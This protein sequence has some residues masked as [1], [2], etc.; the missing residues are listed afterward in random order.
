MPDEQ[1]IPRVTAEGLLIVTRAKRIQTR[2]AELEAV[3]RCEAR[4]FAITSPGN[5][6]RW[7]LLEVAVSRWR[8]MEAAAAQ[9]GPFVYSVTRTSL[10]A[11]DLSG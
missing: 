4:M 1:W 5:L 6:G 10:K 8:D 2:T 7:E 3:R 9:P 11:V